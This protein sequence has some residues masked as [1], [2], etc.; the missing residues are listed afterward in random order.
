MRYLHH[1]SANEKFIASG[2]YQ[3]YQGQTLT[4]YQESWTMHEVGDGAQL[5]RIDQD[6]RYTGTWSRLAEILISP[7]DRVERVNI[8][9]A[10]SGTDKPYHLLK[11]DY[12]FLEAYVQITRRV[13]DAEPD[14]T[15]IAIAPNL[16][17]R[18]IDFSLLWGKSLLKSAAANTGELPVFV[19]FHKPGMP[20]GQ[21]VKGMLPE[22]EDTA[23]EMLDIGQKSFPTIRYRTRGDRVVWLDEHGIPL[24]IIQAR[25]TNQTEILTNYAHV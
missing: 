25:G 9:F 6:A 20:P 18:L 22:I 15:E 5:I 10:Q 7:E 12:V 11:T 24:K 1:V 8:L 4:R 21:I 2:V 17:V 16:F 14:Y 23:E 19:P 13:D 3:Q